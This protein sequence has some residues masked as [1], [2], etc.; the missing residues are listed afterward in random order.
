MILDPNDW[1]NMPE[2]LI[3]VDVIKVPEPTKTVKT[4][5]MDDVPW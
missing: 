5:H 2:P 1:D 3:D 4:L